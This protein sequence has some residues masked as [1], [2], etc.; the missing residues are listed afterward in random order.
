MAAKIAECRVKNGILGWIFGNKRVK[1]NTGK[2]KWVFVIR[3]AL[4]AEKL[5][6][7]FENCWSWKLSSENL[8]LRSTWRP[9]DSSFE[10]K[11][12]IC[13]FCGWWFSNQSEIVP[14]TSFSCD[15]VGREL[16]RAI[17]CSLLWPE[18][19]WNIRV[20]KQ[21]YVFILNNFKWCFDASFLT[22]ISVSTIILRLSQVEFS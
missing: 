10:W 4:W 17:F 9:F 2:V 21:G 11:E 3:A 18:T 6:S 12:E 22:S 20:G 5:G 8:R 13:V 7:C 19:D 16:W 15:E 1:E 14:E